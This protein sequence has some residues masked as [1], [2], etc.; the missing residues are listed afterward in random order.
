MLGLKD[1]SRFLFPQFPRTGS[2]AA[3]PCTLKDAVFSQNCFTVGLS[4]LPPQALCLPKND[5][6]GSWQSFSE[7]KHVTPGRPRSSGTISVNEATTKVNL[8]YSKV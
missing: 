8:E 7:K 6:T 3:E 1:E 2:S 4:D 5:S